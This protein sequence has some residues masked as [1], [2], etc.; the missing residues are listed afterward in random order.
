MNDAGDLKDDVAMPEGE[1]GEKITKLFKTDEKDTSK[2][3]RVPVVFPGLSARRVPN[4]GLFRMSSIFFSANINAQ[5]LLSLLPWARRPPL[6]PR[7]LPARV[8]LS[9]F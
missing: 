3:P 4:D 7:R 9:D 6:R 8:K 5:T 2:L 1:V